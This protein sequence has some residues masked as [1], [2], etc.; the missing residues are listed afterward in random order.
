MNRDELLQRLYQHLEQRYTNFHVKFIEGTDKLAFQFPCCFS[1]SGMG[2]TSLWSKGIQKM[3]KMMG[4]QETPFHNALKKCYDSKHIFTLNFSNL[5][6]RGNNEDYEEYLCMCIVRSMVPKIGDFKFPD[7]IKLEY[8]LKFLK[9]ITGNSFFII[10]F[11]E[12][13]ELFPAQDSDDWKSTT[14]YHLVNKIKSVITSQDDIKIVVCFT[15]LNSTRMT[16]FQTVSGG[17]NDYYELKLLSV[18]DMEA[19]TNQMSEKF[20]IEGK[21]CDNT[22]YKQ[23]LSILCGNP[24]LLSN[25]LSTCSQFD[26]D[27]TQSSQEV[28]FVEVNKPKSL[29]L[30]SYIPFSIRGFANFVQN[31][32][33]NDKQVMWKCMKMLYEKLKL[34]NYNVIFTNLDRIQ[35]RECFLSLFDMM[36]N[37]NLKVQRG[38]LLPHSPYTFGDLERN[39]YV[40]LEPLKMDSR[41]KC[42]WW[43]CITYL[44]F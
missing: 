23:F 28:K 11:D 31:N 6:A 37:Y 13:Q 17:S 24:R 14:L 39:G 32:Y 15:G 36:L 2:K 18:D 26:V 42:L 10:Q 9:E 41:S 29:N 25:F 34:L 20:K 3:I 33:F 44:L 8:L 22:V 1:A 19:I 40:Y 5:P 38:K 16:Q 35:N 7:T 43:C 21:K 27:T 4:N 30:D 12:T